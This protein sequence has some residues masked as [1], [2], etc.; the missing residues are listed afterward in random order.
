MVVNQIKF[1]EWVDKCLAISNN[2]YYNKNMMLR[3]AVLVGD[4][5]VQN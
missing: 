1:P 4:P 2:G 3:A 5:S